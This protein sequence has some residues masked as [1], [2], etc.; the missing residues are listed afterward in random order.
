MDVT[1]L[2]LR[3]WSGAAVVG[4]L[5][6]LAVVAMQAAAAASEPVS[7]SVAATLISDNAN[8][9]DQF[10]I[11]AQRLA[12]EVA[13]DARAAPQV[14]PTLERLWR[15][16]DQEDAGSVS[17]VIVWIVIATL[18]SLAAERLTVLA[19]GRWQE[20]RQRRTESRVTL[21]GLLGF[22]ASDLTGVVVFG[23]TLYLLRAWWFSASTAPPFL[24]VAAFS[25]MM[26]WRT[27]TLISRIVL[28]PR[29]TSARLVPLSDAEASRLALILSVVILASATLVTLS[30]GLANAALAEGVEHLLR[31]GIGVCMC[32]LLAFAVIR[33]RGAAE[34]LIRGDQSNGSASDIRSALASAWVG[35]GLTT[36]AILMVLFTFGLSLG[37]LSYFYALETSLLILLFLLVL[38][39]MITHPLKISAP[40]VAHL[41]A[42]YRL[43]SAALLG[44][45]V[46][47]L[48]QAWIDALP[49]SAAAA[50][51][52]AYSVTGGVVILLFAYAVWEAAKLAIDRH[53]RGIEGSASLPGDTD[54]DAAE[55][56]TRLQT[57]LPFVRAFLAIVIAVLAILIVLSRLGVD[58]APLIAGASI[59]G[60][61][62]SFGSQS[63][64]RDIISG[65]FC[66]WDDA[67]RVGEYIEGDHLKGTVEKLGLRSVKLRHQNGPVHT[68]PY[69]QLGAVTNLSRDF[70]T[71]KFNLQLQLDSDIELVRKTVK[72][73]GIEM[74]EN[75]E[76]AAEI[77]EPLKLQGVA[78]IGGN[79]LTVRLKFTS[80]PAKPSW[81]QREYLKRLNFE[82]REKGISFATGAL[83]LQTL[84]ALP[85]GS[86]VRKSVV[87]LPPPAR[88]A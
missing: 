76:I 70:A 20:A 6:A 37:L 69:G 24:A 7:P 78:E 41:H 83:T 14:L 45:G 79:A 16:M 2:R 44:C 15:S 49:L 11:I 64:V 27:A 88:I 35:A 54:D 31:L 81:I 4:V 32:G 52:A 75:P 59:L 19:Y 63:L 85:E 34:A 72:R 40:A 61:A 36:V 42:G 67:F 50:A 30:R 25:I 43:A 26:H 39:A 84:P 82:F 12:H 38:E 57:I 5:F 66:M 17:A 46:V 13:T 23:I 65:L 77:L 68:I 10:E 8:P 47:A 1:T 71:I 73:I 80:K 18:I 48:A 60:L 9:Q 55:P 87:E 53:L 33:S 29:L 3:F 86:P 28:R 56:A 58:T 21:A 22:L 62:V 74:Q 51:H